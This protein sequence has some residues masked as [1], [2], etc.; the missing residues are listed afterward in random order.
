MRWNFG[1]KLGAFAFRPLE[2]DK[3]VTIQV[4]SVRSGKTWSCQPKM[5]YASSADCKIEGR[6]ILF[7]VSKETIYRDILCDLIDIIGYRNFSRNKQ[8]GE[9]SICGSE[10]QMVGARDEG[11]EK[12]LRG[13][14]IGVAVGHELTLFPQSFFQMLLSRMSPPGARLYGTTNP[15]NPFHWLK[16]DIIDNVDMLAA[17]DLEVINTTMDDNPNLAPEFIEQQKRQYTGV[18]Y[19]RFIKG[20]WVAASGAIY[21]DALSAENE[22]DDSSRP[23][24][25]L[26]GFAARYIGVDYGTTNPCVFVDVYDDGTTLWQ[27][28]EYYWDSKVAMRQKTDSEYAEDMVKF[29]GNRRGLVIVVDPSAASFKV[30]LNRRGLIVKDANNDVTEGIRR[31]AAVMKQRRYRIHKSCT[32]TLKELAS[33]AWNN[34]AAQRGVEE[35]IKAHDHT[36]DAVRY[37]VHTMIPKWRIG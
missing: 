37:V 22:Y 8:T 26:N 3:K 11:S 1:A 31:T 9:F 23:V 18:F 19:D 13:A 36:A 28:R 29:V 7:G 21:G 15:D 16:T 34:K 14:T 25:L 5:L 30:E 17:G 6:K 20:L 2:L 10:W 33:Y 35:P 32:H 4:G 12:Y 27:E 24:G